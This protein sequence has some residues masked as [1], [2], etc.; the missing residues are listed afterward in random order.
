MNEDSSYEGNDV[1]IKLRIRDHG[2][3][4]P[5]RTDHSENHLQPN[6]PTPLP[7]GP[8]YNQPQT[9]PPPNYALTGGYNHHIIR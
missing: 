6:C 4:L 1:G 3:N 5:P 8:S 2:M 9:A 7:P